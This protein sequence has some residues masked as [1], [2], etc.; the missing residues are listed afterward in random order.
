MHA[1]D[2]YLLDGDGICKQVPPFKQDISWQPLL[3]ILF[4]LFWHRT[5]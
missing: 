1:K 3:L 5:L 2:E 4:I